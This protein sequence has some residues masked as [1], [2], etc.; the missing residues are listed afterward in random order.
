MTIEP[1]DLPFRKLDAD[2]HFDALAYCP[3]CRSTEVQIVKSYTSHFNLV[4]GTE[5]DGFRVAILPTMER[6]FDGCNYNPAGPWHFVLFLRCG[7]NHDI[8]VAF[9]TNK[10]MTW[11]EF[12]C[13]GHRRI[14]VPSESVEPPPT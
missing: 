5:E 8:R 12:E 14:D 6:A 7:N 9:C 2:R 1:A 4:A 10:G 3:V 13:D 11:V